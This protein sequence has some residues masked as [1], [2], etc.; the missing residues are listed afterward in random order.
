MTVTELWSEQDSQYCGKCWLRLLTAVVRA[1]F[2][3]RSGLLG[4]SHGRGASSSACLSVCVSRLEARSCVRQRVLSRGALLCVAAVWC[5]FL[6]DLE[7]G[8]SHGAK[9]DQPLAPAQVDVRPYSWLHE[10]GEP[11]NQQLQPIRLN[12]Q[13]GPRPAPTRGSSLC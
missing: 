4:R 13:V 6:S 5:S 3:T 9:E 10:P 7:D 12:V 2:V 1:V 8:Q 11:S